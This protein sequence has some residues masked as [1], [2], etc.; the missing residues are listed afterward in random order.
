MAATRFKD[1]AKNAFVKTNLFYTKNV[2]LGIQDPTVFGFKLFF[3]FD[4]PLSPLLFGATRDINEAPGNTAANYLKMINDQQRLYYLEKFVYLLSNI[5]SQTPWYFQS[6]TGLK[7]AWKRDYTKPYLGEEAKLEIA[8]AESVDLRITALMDYYRKACF[9]WKYRREVVP[10]NLRQFKLTVFVYEARYFSNP[11]SIASSPPD[12]PVNYGYGGN[13]Q[14]EAALSNAKL[15]ERLTGPDET[16]NDPIVPQVNTVL[17]V[18]MSTTRNC[19]TFDF[20]EFDMDEGSH[21]DGIS[22]TEP[23]DVTQKFS[24][25]YKEVEE[26]NSYNFWD[27]NRVSDGYIINMNKIVLDDPQPGEPP[28]QAQKPPITPADTSP[29]AGADSSIKEQGELRKA[30]LKKDERY[31]ATVENISG[32]SSE[33]AKETKVNAAKAE[34][35]KKT[36]LDNVSGNSVAGAAQVRIKNAAAAA[37]KGLFAGNVYGFS[38]ADLTGAAG[39]SVLADAGRSLLNKLGV[40]FEGLNIFQDAKEWIESKLEGLNNIFDTSFKNTTGTPPPRNFNTGPSK[41]NTT[42]TPPPANFNTGESLKNTGGKPS[43]NI[44][45]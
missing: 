28:T 19:F 14:G 23:S 2:F 26:I 8:C 3:H 21:L 22:N 9:D 4:T 1:S 12:N 32:E 35:E 40:D 36:T 39:I 37:T 13:I 33:A 38:A 45:E 25:K 34:K 5:N 18:P 10:K 20:C 15:I 31:S 24:I 41:L 27:R 44:Y 6:I 30:Q 42:G 43:G 11:N 16:I 17:G 7:E 29:P